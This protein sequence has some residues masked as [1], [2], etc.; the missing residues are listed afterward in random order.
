[1]RLC[2]CGCGADLSS[3]HPNKKWASG[4]CRQRVARGHRAEVVPIVSES[5]PEPSLTVMAATRAELEAV[6][7]AS[8]ALGVAALKLAV[9]L[10]GS[11][12]TGAGRA[13]LN[14]EWRAT[15]DAALSVAR[16]R[17]SVG[18]LRD[19]LAARRGA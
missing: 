19:E 6:G 13:S 11:A 1:M 10:D 5:E 4:T 15:L 7:Q 12:D 14:R 2:A 18:A 9:R 16:P 8:S 3:A 17:S